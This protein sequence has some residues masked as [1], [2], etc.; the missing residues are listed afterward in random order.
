M[1]QTMFYSWRSFAMLYWAGKL[2][3]NDYTQKEFIYSDADSRNTIYT[4]DIL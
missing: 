1:F 2:S 3:T 4:I